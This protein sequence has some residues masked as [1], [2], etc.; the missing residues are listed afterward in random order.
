[1]SKRCDPGISL[2]L[3]AMYARRPKICVPNQDY[4][5]VK[6]NNI[7]FERSY[8][9]KEMGIPTIVGVPRISSITNFHLDCPCSWFNLCPDKNFKSDFEFTI[10]IKSNKCYAPLPPIIQGPLADIELL[11]LFNKGCTFTV[12]EG[13]YTKIKCKKIRL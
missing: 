9:L 10:N 4:I 5:L 13:C 8:Y 2:R 6:I 7:L 12:M 3:L 1:M 11:K